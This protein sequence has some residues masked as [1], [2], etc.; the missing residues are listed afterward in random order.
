MG[1]MAE[2]YADRFWLTSDNPRSEPPMQI[3]KE[4]ERGISGKSYRVEPDRRLAIEQALSQAV[5]GDVVL[6][7]G[8]GHEQTQDLGKLVIPFDDREVVGQVLS[9]WT[10][11]GK[12]AEAVPPAVEE[13]QHAGSL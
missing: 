10:A 13:L 9:K 5:R 7:A 12:A 6:I 4:I 2:R 1:Q 3:I 8:K 11:R